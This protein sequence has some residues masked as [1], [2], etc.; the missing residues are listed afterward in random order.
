MAG[1]AALAIALAGSLFFKVD[2]AQGREK[3][4]LGLVLTM[5]PFAFVGPLIGPLVDRVKGGHR[6]VILATM[7]LRC[8]VAISMVPAAANDSL[9]LFPEAFA[10]LV[11]AKTYQVARAAVVPAVVRNDLELVEANSKLQLVGGLSG[12][13][14]MA[15]AGLAFLIGPEWVAGCCAVFFAGATA[16]AFRIPVAAKPMAPPSALERAEMA[17]PIIRVEAASM[18][19]IRGVVGFVTFVLAFEL[20]GGHQPEAAEVLARNVGT[21]LARRPGI[22]LVDALGEFPKWYFGVVV[23][24][25]I[26]GGLLG[27]WL[28]PTIRHHLAEEKILIGALVVTVLAGVWGWAMDGVLAFVGLAMG[29]AI[30]ASVGKQAFDSLV[31]RDA[32]DADRGRIFAR[33]EARFQ[34]AWVVGAVVPSAIEFDI[35]VG[36]VIVMLVGAVALAGSMTS[37]FGHLSRS[38][39]SGISNGSSSSGRSLS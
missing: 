7:A 37:G 23:A 24:A 5:A 18:A 11:L 4:L 35:T 25:G 32:P 31:Q 34:I 29:V 3:V 36:A 16:A 30:A 26:L 14:A 17:S 19:A 12:F 27:A 15:P 38:G 8:L 10:M 2:P 28:A 20:R 39:K 21:V 1:E 6:A 22:E 33:F 9:L 13:A